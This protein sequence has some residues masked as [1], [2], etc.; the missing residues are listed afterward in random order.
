M[1][2]VEPV[3]CRLAA[4]PRAQR[5]AF[6]PQLQRHTHTIFPCAIWH[7]ST[8]YTYTIPITSYT[9][10]ITSYTIPIT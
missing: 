7:C 2:S 5:A 8:Q 1:S 3:A 6:D 10:H 9:I 4:V